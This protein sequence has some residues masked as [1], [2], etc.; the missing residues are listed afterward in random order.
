ML[1]NVNELTLKMIKGSMKLTKMQQIDSHK[2]IS[3]FL[4]QLCFLLVY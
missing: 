3:D 2:K 4:T 1:L